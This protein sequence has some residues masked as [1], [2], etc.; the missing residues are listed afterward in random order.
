MVNKSYIFFCFA[1]FL[2]T[3]FKNS[4][5]SISIQGNDT[6]K[7]RLLYPHQINLKM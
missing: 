3:F 2:F 4:I 7:K 1:S 5:K 6:E